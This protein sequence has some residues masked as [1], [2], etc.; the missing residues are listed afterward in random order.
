M[1]IEF[2]FMIKR[3][4]IINKFRAL[5]QKYPATQNY[6]YSKDICDIFLGQKTPK[7]IKMKDYLIWD[8]EEEDLKKIYSKPDIQKKK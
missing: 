6:Y 3:Y 2:I 7:S 1:P 5:F 4:N 8:E